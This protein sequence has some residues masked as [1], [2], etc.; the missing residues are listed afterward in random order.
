MGEVRKPHETSILLPLLTTSIGL[1]GLA[2]SDCIM[3]DGL[4]ETQRVDKAHV[5]QA[6]FNSMGTVW[7][8]GECNVTLL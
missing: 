5:R 7:V 4:E 6:G 3:A 2:L 1:P 8:P